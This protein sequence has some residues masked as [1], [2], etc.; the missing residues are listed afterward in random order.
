MN[1]SDADRITG[2]LGEKFAKLQP[3]PRAGIPD[4]IAQCVVWLA[5]DRS[6]FVNGIDIVVDG[7]MEVNY[8]DERLIQ[9][10]LSGDGQSPNF[11]Q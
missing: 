2:Q 9:G 3:I 10:F 5:S 11:R 8:F 4:D 6:T 1:A 7:G